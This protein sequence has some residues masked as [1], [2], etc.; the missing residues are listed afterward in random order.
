MKGQ[1]IEQ[2]FEATASEVRRVEESA[3]ILR[4]TILDAYQSSP[5]LTWPPSMNLLTS[6]IIQ[7]P[8]I[9]QDFLAILIS[10]KKTD[11]ASDRTHRLVKSM[12]ED[13]CKA[14]TRGQRTMPKQ[15][16][17]GVT[18]Q[19]MTGSADIITLLN[20]FGHCLS[21][22]ALLELETAMRKGVT[23]RD[24][25]L[26]PTIQPDGNRVIHLCWLGQL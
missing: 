13:I 10:G 22:S 25:V 8:S 4:R 11:K 7:A 3:S 19:H 16:L 21:Y 5:P 26:P 2:A 23:Q 15:L 24:S 6:G 9:L 17:L 14:A 18:I 12:S 20:R 1:A